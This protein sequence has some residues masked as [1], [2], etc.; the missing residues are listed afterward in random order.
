MTVSHRYTKATQRPHNIVHRPHKTRTEH[1]QRG[2]RA[3]HTGPDTATESPGVAPTPPNAAFSSHA[4]RE[5]RD[6]S[7][8]VRRDLTR[9]CPRFARDRVLC[10]T[11]SG[12]WSQNI[13]VETAWV[14]SGRWRG[15]FARPWNQND[16][17]LR[18][19]HQP[20]PFFEWPFTPSQAP[21]PTFSAL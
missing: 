18:A 15:A 14:S 12:L 10:R 5:E 13:A 6:R 9:T 4:L 8:F 20:K 2:A 19:L 11:G 17:F 7:D 21:N 1:A 3:M 16:E